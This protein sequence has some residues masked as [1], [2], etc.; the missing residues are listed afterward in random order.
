[1]IPLHSFIHC[2]GGHSGLYHF[3]FLRNDVYFVYIFTLHLHC[4]IIEGCVIG[5]LKEVGC[6]LSFPIQVRLLTILPAC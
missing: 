5:S 6:A 2:G 4:V 1:V 3:F